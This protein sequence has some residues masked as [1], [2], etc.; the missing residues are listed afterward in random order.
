[1]DKWFVKNVD[2]IQKTFSICKDIYP[3]Y[4]N[5]SAFISIYDSLEEFNNP[6]NWEGT[7]FENL[8]DVYTELKKDGYA[9]NI[10]GKYVFF[11]E[12][13][14]KL[15]FNYLCEKNNYF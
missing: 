2:V 5:Y 12:N 8:K 15:Y 1:M 9:E 10:S 6:K 7:V 3:D 14:C 13:L 11:D 4:E